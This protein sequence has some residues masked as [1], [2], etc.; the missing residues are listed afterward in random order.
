MGDRLLEAKAFVAVAQTLSFTQAAEVLGLSVS[1]LS[2]LISALER[3]LGTR[4]LHR[5]T[6]SVTLTV[7][8]AELLPRFQAL[9]QEAE[10][11]FAPYG[12]ELQGTLR[13]AASMPF[14]DLELVSLLAQ[15]QQQHPKLR[16][17]F[18]LTAQPLDLVRGSVDVGF[19]E[20]G[21]V[22]EGYI[23]RKLGAIESWMVASPVYLAAAGMPQVPEDLLAHRI[24]SLSSCHALWQF[25]PIADPS[26]QLDL[27]VKP[28]FESN[29]ANAMLTMCLA[30][31]GITFQAVRATEDL[32]RA[33]RLVVVLPQYRGLPRLAYAAVASRLNLSPAVRA[34]LDFVAA[35]L[36]QAGT[37]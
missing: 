29:Y 15:F 2:R 6:R 13:V 21:V 33:G 19:Q 34:L 32:V 26:A 31:N 24:L 12:D 9:V 3:T 7:Q 11:L 20:G 17:N 37:E 4:L 5:T 8:G 27:K 10:Q 30:G 23:A 14:F 18:S 25:A 1:V 36:A 22:A 35:K 28:C 16:L